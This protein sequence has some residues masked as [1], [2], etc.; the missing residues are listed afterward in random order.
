LRKYTQRE[1]AMNGLQNNNPA[2]DVPLI[3]ENYQKIVDGLMQ[4]FYYKGK[5]YAS[6]MPFNEQAIHDDIYYDYNTETG[7][8]DT[9]PS[10]YINFLMSLPDIKVTLV[11]NKDPGFFNSYMHF[12]IDTKFAQEAQEATAA[13]KTNPTIAEK[14]AA[15]VEILKKGTTPKGNVSKPANL[16][17]YQT[18]TQW[19]FTDKN[20][21]TVN[22]Y[23]HEGNSL[24]RSCWCIYRR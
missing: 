23:N 9:E 6:K 19:V 18:Q 1:A 20:G 3:P 14:K 17:G 15:I 8:F 12:S 4:G 21:S 5:H 10:S 11:E 7:T 24:S 22:F 2:I 16:A 13:A